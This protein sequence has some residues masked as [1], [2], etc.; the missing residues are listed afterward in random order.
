MNESESIIFLPFG[1]SY[2]ALTREQ[3]EDAMARGRE[4]VPLLPLT[5]ASEEDGRVIDADEAARIIGIPASW[6]LEQA[7]QGK[8]HHLR[9]GKYVRFRLADLLTA[10]ATELRN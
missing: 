6:F 8:I 10:A 1:Q 9:F 7:R 5:E 2:L 3:F 4:L